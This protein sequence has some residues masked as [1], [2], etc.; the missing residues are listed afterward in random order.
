MQKSKIRQQ[1]TVGAIVK[2]P[3]EGGYHTYARILEGAFFAFYDCKTKIEKDDLQEIINSPILFITSVYNEVITT[4]QWLKIGKIPLEENLKIMPP[5]FIQDPIYKDQ[6]RI[7]YNDRTE[8]EA[9]IEECK[10]LERFMIWNGIGIQKRISDHYSGRK[11]ETVEEMRNPNLWRN[12]KHT[13]NSVNK[14]KE[15]KIA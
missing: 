2:I 8:K 13:N 6:L 10:G 12:N 9:T 11:N 15:R 14:I 7:V 1:R 3:L 5:V 4:G